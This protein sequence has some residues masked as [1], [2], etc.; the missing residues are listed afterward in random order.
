VL[1][2]GL[3]GAFFWQAG[4]LVA[5][6]IGVATAGVFHLAYAGGSTAEGSY[7]DFRGLLGNRSY[8]LLATAGLCLGAVFYTTTGYTVLYVE[9]SVGAA[10][11]VGGVVLAALQVCSSLGRVVSG[12]LGDALPGSPS[13]RVGSVLAA[14]ALVG[15]VLFLLLPATTTALGAGV[16]LALVGLF[17]LGSVGLYYSL[18]S[19]VVSEDR[20]GS[21]SAGGQLAATFGGLVTPP[22]FGYLTEAAGY[23]AGWGLLGG[24]SLLAVGSVAAVVFAS[25]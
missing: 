3:V 1:V 6:A 5:A 21:A 15:G 12:W 2:T 18:V 17:A 25:R 11:A 8:L 20:I 23:A 10:V 19:I 7:P 22:V 14:Q 16:V 4:F 24:L 9:E 13:T